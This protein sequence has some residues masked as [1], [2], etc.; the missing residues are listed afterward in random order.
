MS[1][2]GPRPQVIYLGYRQYPIRSI[3]LG[4]ELPFQIVGGAIADTLELRGSLLPLKKDGARY[5]APGRNQY[6]GF[7]GTSN[8]REIYCGYSAHAYER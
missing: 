4:F 7:L 3:S 2:I 6:W 5:I 8:L 1:G